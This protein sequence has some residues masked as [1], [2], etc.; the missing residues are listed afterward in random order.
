MGRATEKLEKRQQGKTHGQQQQDHLDD[1]GFHL[2]FNPC[3]RQQQILQ[4]LNRKIIQ[5]VVGAGNN[6]LQ[7]RHNQLLERSGAPHRHDQ[8]FEN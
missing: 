2:L 1:A 8:W 3:V 5:I 7:H 6:P 4:V